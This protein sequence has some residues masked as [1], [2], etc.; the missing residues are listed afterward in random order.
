[1][2]AARVGGSSWANSPTS[3]TRT[4]ADIRRLRA[5]EMRAEGMT[6]AAIGEQLGITS[7]SAYKAVSKAIKE[8]AEREHEAAVEVRQMQHLRC[9]A[10][11]RTYVPKALDGD[12]KSAQLVLKVM[13]RE[14]A[15]YGLDTAPRVEV[16][17]SVNL[18]VADVEEARKIGE[19][20]LRDE[21]LEAA[22]ETLA[23]AMAEA[24][25]ANGGRPALP[26]PQQVEEA[27]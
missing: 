25:E 16:A 21:T 18:T 1:V 5:L 10:L 26:A 19:A 15:L 13:E 22:L 2:G 7:A 12:I 14:A 17:G 24:A 23:R 3:P 9:Q 20:A 27:S 6:F 8:L 11:Y 4:K